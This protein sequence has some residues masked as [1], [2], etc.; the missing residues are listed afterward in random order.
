MPGIVDASFILLSLNRYFRYVEV[1]SKRPYL[2][3]V[4]DISNPTDLGIRFPRF[5]NF[6]DFPYF[7]GFTDSFR[8]AASE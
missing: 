8:F 1:E 6:L 2:Q 3:G 4:I 5:P 7:L